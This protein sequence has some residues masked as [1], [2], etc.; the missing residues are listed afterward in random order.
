M[1]SVDLHTYSGF[2]RILPES[3]A[4][5][6]A[7]K[8]TPKYVKKNSCNIHT[9]FPSYGIFHL[10]DPPGLKAILECK[11]KDAFHPPSRLT[12]IY[13]T[14]CNRSGDEI[15]IARTGCEQGIQIKEG[16]PLEIVD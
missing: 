14:Y 2:Q 3:F 6:C 7:P 15:L 12:N 9:N 11:E 4:V 16:A 5:V 1:S 13:C 8:S 10:T